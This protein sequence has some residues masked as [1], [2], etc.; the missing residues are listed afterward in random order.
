METYGR[1]G[2]ILVPQYGVDSILSV[3]RRPTSSVWVFDF[4]PRF[5]SGDDVS[6]C[7][8]H[9][10]LCLSKW[11]SCRQFRC[12]LLLARNRGSVMRSDHISQFTWLLDTL[13]STV[14]CCSREWDV[15]DRNYERSLI[16]GASVERKEFQFPSSANSN[17]I[18][19]P[20][21]ACNVPAVS[22]RQQCC[23]FIYSFI[24]GI[25]NDAVSSSGCVVSNYRWFVN[26]R[27]GK[28]AKQRGRGLV[29]M[30]KSSSVDR[31]CFS[32]CISLRYML[33]LCLPSHHKDMWESWSKDS[34][35]NSYS[36][37]KRWMDGPKNCSGQSSGEP[38]KF[39]YL[40]RM[41]P[42]L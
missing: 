35:F 7:P 26:N 41:K 23:L 40:P 6:V 4:L 11:L 28:D 14:H 29:I 5:K 42:R 36:P 20:K 3:W 25:F 33:P 1:T 22:L 38:K 27:S 13:L 2:F 18:S 21:F 15:L 30:F 31:N 19:G 8:D 16:P 37:K 24:C 34:R 39:L 9:A 17:K 32:T 10:S 12:V